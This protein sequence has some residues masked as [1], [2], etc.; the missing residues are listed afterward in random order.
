[1]I[2]YGLCKSEI[3]LGI[4]LGECSAKCRIVSRAQNM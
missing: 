1:M 3:I 4:T 2:V